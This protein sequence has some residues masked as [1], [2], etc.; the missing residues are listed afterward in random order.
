MI[1]EL[2]KLFGK[3]FLIGYLLPGAVAFLF[4][5]GIL[6]YYLGTSIYGWLID[7]IGGHDEKQLAIRLS[8]ALAGAW[9]LGTVLLSINHNLIRILEGY[10]RV[11]PARLMRWRSKR[12]FR[13]LTDEHTGIEN[14][15]VDGKVPPNLRGA[16][17]RVRYRLANEFPE[18]EDLVL[19]TRF[20]NVVRA[21]ERYPQIIYSTEAIETW[22]RLQALI[23][24]RYG[25]MLD[26]AKAQLD[27]WVNL[28]FGFVVLGIGSAGVLVWKGP[29]GLAVPALVSFALAVAAARAARTAA[30]QWGMLVKGA[31]DLYRGELSKQLGL[32][33]PRSVAHERQMWASVSRTF[34]NRRPD[35]ADKLTIFRPLKRD[36]E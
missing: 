9:I 18:R 7:V 34:L 24:E 35:D 33:I 6:D 15:R 23:P 3:T 36:E 10:G 20:G 27:F 11:N 14:R 17:S 29:C 4:G 19:P 2:P 31:F 12:I 21:F 26:D 25:A 16:H 8:L 5:A 30:A 28:W 32:E 22:P 13:G 1:G